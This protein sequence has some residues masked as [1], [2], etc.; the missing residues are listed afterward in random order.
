MEP[1][2]ST[3]LE[4]ACRAVNGTTELAKLLS[5]RRPRPVSK[6]SVSRW[7]KEGVPAEM[8]PDIEELTGVPC[9][10]LRPDVNWAALR[11]GPRARGVRKAA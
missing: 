2:T 1:T 6:A 3:P 9:E 7:K 10:D 11:K 5:G 8:C 4:A